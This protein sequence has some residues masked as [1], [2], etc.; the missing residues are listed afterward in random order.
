[1]QIELRQREKGMFEKLRWGRLDRNQTLRLLVKVKPLFLNLQ[2]KI[3]II[4]LSLTTH[5]SI[6]FYLY[7]SSLQFKLQMD[8][9]HFTSFN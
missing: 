9:C 8:G 7:Y 6:L 3:L 5:S 4:S 2:P 1:M